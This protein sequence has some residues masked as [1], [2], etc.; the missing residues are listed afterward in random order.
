MAAFNILSSCICRDAFGFQEDYKH[1]V[2]TFLQSTSPIT[3]FQ[4]N[5]R[6][7]QRIEMEML[8][9]IDSLYRFQKKCIVKDYNKEILSSYDKKADYFIL[10]LVSLASTGI[11]SIECD[12]EQHFFTYSKWFNRAYCDGL[13]KYLPGKIR[14]YNA[15][16]F[17]QSHENLLEMTIDGIVDWLLNIK[18]Y[19]E[20]QIILVR[21]KRVDCWSDSEYLYYFDGKSSREKVNIK[22]DEAYDYF[23]KKM[24]D[25]HMIRMPFDTYADKFHKWGLTELHFC[26]EFYDYLYL[27]F[28]LIAA[29]KEKKLSDAFYEYSSILIKKKEQ[30]LLNSVGILEKESL[31]ESKLDCNAEGYIIEKNKEYYSRENGEYVS[32]GLLKTSVPIHE[33]GRIYSVVYVNDQKFYVNTDDCEKGYVGHETEV[34]NSSWKLQN[35]STL[36]VLKNNS[37]ILKNS[38]SSL[39]AQMQIINTVENAEKLKGKALTFSVWA[40][41]LEY[42]D[43]GKGGQISFINANNYNAGVFCAKENIDNVVW[44]KISVYYHVPQDGEFKGITVCLRA[45][46]GSDNNGKAAVVEFHSPK[47]EIGSLGI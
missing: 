45:L 13:K 18:G 24:P 25:C 42:N 4:Y 20:D 11:A 30:L 27:C 36:V 37:F 31:I 2:I 5:K 8:E 22:L 33:W 6:P 21:N 46:A 3:W 16:N 29:G 23:Y 7:E 32:Q 40:R 15:V 41:V 26:K 38:G 17:L 39:K 44:K 10:D 47:L 1:E 12:N 34:G 35:K 19:T 28:D 9:D 43:A 14:K